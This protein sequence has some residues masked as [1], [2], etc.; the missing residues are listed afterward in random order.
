M[1]PALRVE[2]T[3]IS[4]FLD[5]ASATKQSQVILDESGSIRIAG[6]ADADPIRLT[7]LASP[8]VDGDAVNI[9][10]VQTAK[11]TS[12]Y[13]EPVYILDLNVPDPVTTLSVP[14]NQGFR[15]IDNC[16]QTPW[17]PSN[18][19]LQGGFRILLMGQ[20][21]ARQNGIWIGGSNGAD[22]IRPVTCPRAATW[23]CT[24]GPLSAI[25]KDGMWC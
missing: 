25:Q 5:E 3:R 11:N 20:T 10:Y 2:S 23:N 16:R 18:F 8:L 17:G 12:R 22:A 13:K 7:G 21:D 6:P 4:A 9:Q 24:K 1:A 14:A 15:I 19:G